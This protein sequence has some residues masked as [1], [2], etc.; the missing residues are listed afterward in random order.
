MSNVKAVYL[1]QLKKETQ[2]A[3]N[4]CH[5]GLV[6][7]AEKNKIPEEIFVNNFLPFF[8]G[9]VSLTETKENVIGTWI[10]IAGSPSS[11]VDV[12]DSSGN[13]LYEVPAILKNELI[14]PVVVEQ[15]RSL[16]AILAEYRARNKNSPVIGNLFIT[17]ELEKK[18]EELTQNAPVNE[19]NEGWNQIMT[20]YGLIEGQEVKAVVKKTADE[21]SDDEFD[22]S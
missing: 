12:I 20:R 19:V 6:V 3:I 7:N 16:P 5:T 17:Q 13:V 21:L 11:P 1:D 22:Y 9:K 10:G 14:D 4:K 2:D 18:S 8:S 15:K